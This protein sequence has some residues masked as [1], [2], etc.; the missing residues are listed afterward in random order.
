MQR[1]TSVD[2]CSCQFLV[3]GRVDDQ[4]KFLR[5]ADVDIPEELSKEVGSPQ[6]H[7]TL[8]RLI[9]WLPHNLPLFIAM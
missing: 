2:A 1:A 3:A 4:G 9:D 7:D 8:T 6:S 5:L